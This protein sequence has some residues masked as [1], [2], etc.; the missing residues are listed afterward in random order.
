MIVRETIGGGVL[1]S[2]SDKVAADRVGK[3][4][5]EW[6]LAVGF[7]SFLLLHINTH[8]VKPPMNLCEQV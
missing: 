2:L 3:F 7:V 4:E 8:H 1:D 6:P 5:L